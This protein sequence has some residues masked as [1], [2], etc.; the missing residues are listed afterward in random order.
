[1]TPTKNTNREDSSVSPESM[2]GFCVKKTCQLKKNPSLNE[3]KRKTASETS[4]LYKEI[5]IRILSN[6]SLWV[7]I[8]L[9][10]FSS[11][12]F[13]ICFYFSITLLTRNFLIDFLFNCSWFCMKEDFFRKKLEKN[14]LYFFNWINFLYFKWLANKTFKLSSQWR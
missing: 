6:G 12:L 1:M 14:G 7:D 8:S 3:L 13:P 10:A 9:S 11:K 4:L 5:D 2:C